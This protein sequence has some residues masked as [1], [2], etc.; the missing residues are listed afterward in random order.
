MSSDSIEDYSNLIPRRVKDKIYLSEYQIS[1]LKRF[2]IDYNCYNSLK[3]IIFDIE[4]ILN[5]VNDPELESVS[6]EISEFNYYN[7]TNK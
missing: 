3:G 4:N 5:E 6:L 2:N 1:V 7:N